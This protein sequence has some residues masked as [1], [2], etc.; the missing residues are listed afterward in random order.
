MA[1]RVFYLKKSWLVFGCLNIIG[2]IFWHLRLWGLSFK[3][4]LFLVKRKSAIPYKACS[5][6]EL[7]M[8]SQLLKQ[9]EAASSWSF[10]L[11]PDQISWWSRH[12]SQLHNVMDGWQSRQQVE[13]VDGQLLLSLLHLW[14]TWWERPLV[15]D[16]RTHSCR[17]RKNPCGYWKYAW[18]YM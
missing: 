6:H 16:R 7:R 9:H 1:L 15:L 14:L 8:I 2:R 17:S 5:Y 11:F 10:P 12:C 18:S 3:G 4:G 13:A